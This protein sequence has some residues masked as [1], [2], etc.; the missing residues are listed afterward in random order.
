MKKIIIVIGIFFFLFGGCDK[1]S[2]V[3]SDDATYTITPTAGQN[4]TIIPSTPVVLESGKSQRFI[5]SPNNGYCIDTVFVDGKEVDSLNG[6]TFLNVTS[7]QT[8]RV[9]FSAI[10]AELWNY[11]TNTEKFAA[12]VHSNVATIKN[13]NRLEVL[14]VYYNMTNVF[15]TA[16]ELSFPQDKIFVRDFIAG[17]YI[18][19]NSILTLKKVNNTNGTISFG[20][21]YTANSGNISNGSG[22]LFKLKCR[23]KNAGNISFTINSSKLQILQTDGM[24]IPNFNSIQIENLNMGIQ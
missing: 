2:P 20:I 13:G 17:S 1:S 22:A 3:K 19:G 6:Y 24:P 23:A 21:T 12:T 11:P 8:I 4:G 18:S 15:G 5:F 10:S 7:N 9:V 14:V 16:I